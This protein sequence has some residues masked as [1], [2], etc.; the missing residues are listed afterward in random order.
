MISVGS[1]TFFYPC[2]S[3]MSLFICLWTLEYSLRTYYLSV[4]VQ[5][6]PWEHRLFESR[7]PVCSSD[8]ALGT[9]EVNVSLLDSE[10]KGLGCKQIVKRKHLKRYSH[11][12]SLAKE[13]LR[14]SKFIQKLHALFKASIQRKTKR[15]RTAEEVDISSASSYSL[16]T[17][18]TG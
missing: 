5:P 2:E 16:G 9:R 14:I 18:F 12:L 3:D 1:S 11:G 6:F 4:I 8:I 10:H 15:C 7:E 13:F 17:E